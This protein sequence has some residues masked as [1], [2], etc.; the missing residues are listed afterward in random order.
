MEVSEE[1]AMDQEKQ[2]FKMEP[3]GLLKITEKLH[4]WIVEKL[5]K[6]EKN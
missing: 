5:E 2:T 1:E 6:W 3:G 4:Y